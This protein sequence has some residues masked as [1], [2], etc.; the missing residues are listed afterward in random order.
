MPDYVNITTTNGVRH[1]FETRRG[2]CITC[3]K[4]SDDHPV[5]IDNEP[6]AI[7][8][9]FPDNLRIRYPGIPDMLTVPHEEIDQSGCTG[10]HCACRTDTNSS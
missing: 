5:T 7:L 9:V 1:L 4:P 8:A 6:A 3:G 10:E 2:T